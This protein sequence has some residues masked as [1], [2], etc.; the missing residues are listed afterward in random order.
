MTSASDDGATMRMAQRQQD[1]NSGQKRFTSRHFDLGHYY[2]PPLIL[3]EIPDPIPS[4]PPMCAKMD[5]QVMTIDHGADYTNTQNSEFFNSAFHQLS[6]DL[7]TPLNHI[8][9]FAELLLMD[10]ELS[11]TNI[12]YVRAILSG[13]ERLKA[14]V[15]SHL[16]CA[17]AI[18]VAPPNDAVATHHPASI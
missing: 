1:D 12:E 14:A 18:A 15:T 7:R 11:P 17:E 4:M 13:S 3:P 9:G 2:R 10:K 6:H 16:S 8:N 5:F